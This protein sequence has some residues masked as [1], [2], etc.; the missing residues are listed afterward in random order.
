MTDINDIRR[1]Q[2]DVPSIRSS[3][4]ASSTALHLCTHS[5]DSPKPPPPNIPPA[6]GCPNA[7]AAGCPNAPVC[8]GCCAAGCP[9]NP[10]DC[11]CGCC[12]CV[13]QFP[14][15][16]V[17]DEEEGEGEEDESEGES[18]RSESECE[19]KA[20]HRRSESCRARL[21]L[22][23]V[24]WWKRT[25]R[26]STTD[27]LIGVSRHAILR[28]RYYHAPPPYLYSSKSS[29]VSNRLSILRLLW[30]S[31]NCRITLSSPSP[32]STESRPV[33]VRPIR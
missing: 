27:M 18:G 13:F 22:R 21:I 14:P 4:R 2:S 12:C 30:C 17:V 20:D 5:L 3:P 7:P 11:C 33:M 6:A 28:Y 15:N 23:L 26:A 32:S 8:A 1:V 31:F 29:P 16:I 25:G 10:V 19:V 9:N 24:A